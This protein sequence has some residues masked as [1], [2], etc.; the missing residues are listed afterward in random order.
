[1]HMYTLALESVHVCGRYQPLIQNLVHENVINRLFLQ[2]QVSLGSIITTH[3]FSPDDL[4]LLT[5]HTWGEQVKVVERKRG[6]A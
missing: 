1:M 5:T 4:Y 2:D 3:G 6:L